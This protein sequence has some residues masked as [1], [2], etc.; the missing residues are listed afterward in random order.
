MWRQ[1]HNKICNFIFFHF[2]TSYIY[3][4]TVLYCSVYTCTTPVLCLG[5]ILVYTPVPGYPDPPVHLYCYPI[6]VL[7]LTCIIVYINILL[8]RCT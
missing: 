2:H 1:N 5:C 8:Y 6:G 3:C 7:V 4:S